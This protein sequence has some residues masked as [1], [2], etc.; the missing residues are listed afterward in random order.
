MA[1]SVFVEAEEVE[2]STVETRVVTRVLVF[3]EHLFSSQ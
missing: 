3:N 2:H 1:E